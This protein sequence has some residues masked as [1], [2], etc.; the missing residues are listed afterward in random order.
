[1]RAMMAPPSSLV[2]T[3][4]QL[5]R[6]QKTLRWVPFAALPHSTEKQDAGKA[7]QSI[8]EK[9]IKCNK[10]TVFISHN[11][12]LCDIPPCFLADILKNMEIMRSPPLRGTSHLP[13]V[14]FPG[15]LSVVSVTLHSTLS[16]PFFL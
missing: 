1:M 10:R 14:F 5:P 15:L 3:V 11:F 4:G 6:A 16:P 12:L 8:P 9:H 13:S 7:I 2:G